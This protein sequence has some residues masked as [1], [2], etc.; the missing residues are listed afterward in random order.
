MA[1]SLSCLWEQWRDTKKE[2]TTYCESIQHIFRTAA[3]G[4]VA[5]PYVVAATKRDNFLR[6]CQSSSPYQTLRSVVNEI[7]PC[8]NTEQVFPLTSY[9]SDSNSYWCVNN[10]EETF[11][12]MR[13]ITT[14]AMN[15]NPGAPIAKNRCRQ[16]AL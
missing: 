10:N 2:W 12:L 11:R 4:E 6:E 14:L 7:K 16:M 1:P 5:F 13:Q 15:A 9:K 8:A 3:G